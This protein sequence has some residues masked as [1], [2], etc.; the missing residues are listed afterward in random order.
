[1]S[2][3]FQASKILPVLKGLFLYFAATAFA[4]TLVVYGGIKIPGYQIPEP[5]LTIFGTTNLAIVVAGIVMVIILPVI[6]EIIFRKLLLQW[7]VGK[8]GALRG[9]MATALLFAAINSA[10]RGFVPVFILGLILNWLFVTSKSIR[11]CILLHAIVSLSAFILDI[12][13]IKGVIPLDF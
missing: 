4:C 2:K 10:Y 6:Q 11:S 12:L 5:I 7:L 8:V 3:Y 1:M 9:S 13:L